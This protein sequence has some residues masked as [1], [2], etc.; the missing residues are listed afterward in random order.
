[1]QVPKELEQAA[2]W[3]VMAESYN[4]G[5]MVRTQVCAVSL[6]LLCSLFTVVALV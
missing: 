4:I 3:R 1:M 5:P 2:D 6:G